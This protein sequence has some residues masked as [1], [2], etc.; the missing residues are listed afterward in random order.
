[1]KVEET[2]LCKN[3]AHETVCI[4]TQE[5]EKAKSDIQCIPEDYDFLFPIKPSC[6]YFV[7]KAVG[8]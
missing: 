2:S 7:E 3:C 6:K 1:M 4:F 8:I 5:Y